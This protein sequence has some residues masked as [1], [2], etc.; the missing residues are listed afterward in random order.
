LRRRTDATENGHGAVAE[1]VCLPALAETLGELERVQR[2]CKA[3]RN[4]LMTIRERLDGVL[5]DAFRRQSF[6]PLEHLFREE[7]AALKAYKH[8]AARLAA[9]EERWLAVQ[10]ALAYER[11]MMSGSV[12]RHRLN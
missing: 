5:D 8:S 1:L 4:R 3:A 12:P 10:A 6:R 7:E 11:R 2:D 9:A